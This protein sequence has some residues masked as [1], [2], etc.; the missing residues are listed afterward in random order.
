MPTFPKLAEIAF[1]VVPYIK[2]TRRALEDPGGSR[3]TQEDPG[4]ASKSQEEPGGAWDL[5]G[6]SLFSGLKTRVA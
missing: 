3:R 6:W 1:V 5:L 2:R 4:G